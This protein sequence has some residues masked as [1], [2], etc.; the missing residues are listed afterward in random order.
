MLPFYS[1]SIRID[2]HVVQEERDY[3]LGRVFGTEAIIKSG[4]PFNSSHA[5]EAWSRVLDLVYELAQKKGWLR[6]ECG[7]ILYKSIGSLKAYDNG[8]NYAQFL[9]D[10][11][12]AHGLAKSPEGIALWMGIQSTFPNV[13]LPR[14]VWHKQDPLHRKEKATLSN[15]MKDASTV[16]PGQ[17]E[18]TSK[19]AKNTTWSSSLHFAWDIILAS[20]IQQD[21]ADQEKSVKTTS[22]R[23]FWTE[24]VDSE[25][26]SLYFSLELILLR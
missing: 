16:G 2:Q 10:K 15:I 20:L 24:A 21:H 3:Q 13:I 1:R 14:S 22:F 25:L 5:T 4:I 26:L 6:E 19:I 8:I 9:I 17:A 7:W 12:N 23:D 18:A 11:L